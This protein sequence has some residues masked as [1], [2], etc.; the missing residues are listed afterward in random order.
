MAN[1]TIDRIRP[2]DMSK[3]YCKCGNIVSIDKNTVRLKKF[4][5]KELECTACR[6]YRISRDIDHMNWHYDG[7]LDDA[8]GA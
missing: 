8:Q 1:M 5:R 6:N 7:T 3:I 2:Y 4:L